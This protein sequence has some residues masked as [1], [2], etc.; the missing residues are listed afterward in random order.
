MIRLMFRA[1]KAA[2]R[3]RPRTF[4]WQDAGF[5]DSAMRIVNVEESEATVPDWWV[6]VSAD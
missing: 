3:N 5:E 4:N 1:R 6:T 2:A